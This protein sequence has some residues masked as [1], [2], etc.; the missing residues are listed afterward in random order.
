[1]PVAFPAAKAA[2]HVSQRLV[3]PAATRTSI[4]TMGSASPAALTAAPVKTS[5][6]AWTVSLPTSW[7]ESMDANPADSIA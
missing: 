3:A 5:K 6:D 4:S 7:Q 1:M 2:S